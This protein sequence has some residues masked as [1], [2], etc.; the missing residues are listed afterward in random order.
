MRFQ[1]PVNDYV[2]SASAPFLW[3][4][5][6]GPFYFVL[7]GIWRHAV[8][9]FAVNTILFFLAAILFSGSVLMITAMMEIGRSFGATPDEA[10]SIILIVIATSL[11]GPFLFYPFFASGIIRRH[12]LRQGWT[13]I[14]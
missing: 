6:F 2:E 13:E 11:F 8:L 4:F 10:S 14:D 12:F 9:Y 5:L 3:A 7:K 1:N